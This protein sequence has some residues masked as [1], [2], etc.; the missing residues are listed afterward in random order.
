MNKRKCLRE[1]KRKC[2]KKNEQ[3]G[4]K[5][6]CIYIQ[7]E[8]IQEELWVTTKRCQRNQEEKVLKNKRSKE[9]GKGNNPKL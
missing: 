7:A 4:S 5:R 3:R 9:E 2:T 6:K 1:T 8:V